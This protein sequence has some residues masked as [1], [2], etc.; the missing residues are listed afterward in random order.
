MRPAGR[1]LAEGET[2]RFPELAEA[3][4]R[5]GAEGPE[6]FYSGEVGTALADRVAELGGTLSREDMANYEAVERQPVRAGFR[7]TEVLT[8]PPPSSGGL[9]IAFCLSLLE[10]LGEAGCARRSR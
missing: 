4:E 6:P 5:Y 1:T 2:F 7:G 3:L 10:R 9:L 8:N